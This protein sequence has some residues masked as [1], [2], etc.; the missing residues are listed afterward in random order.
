MGGQ[1]G[2]GESK[3]YYGTLAAWICEGPVESLI[4]VVADDSIVWP[5]AA[6]WTARSWPSGSIVLYHDGQL[7]QAGSTT[8]AEPPASPWVLYGLT[9]ASANGAGYTGINLLTI[10]GCRFYW[11]L[12]SQ[13]ADTILTSSRAGTDVHPPYKGICYCVLDDVKL[14]TNRAGAPNLRFLVTRKP[15]Q[16]IVTGTPSTLV[17]RQANPMAV[18]AEIFTST[19]C[20]LGLSTGRMDGTSWNATATALQSQADLMLISPIWTTK[21]TARSAIQDFTAYGD[22][23]VRYNPNNDK[24]EAGYWQHGSTPGTATVLDVNDWTAVPETEV[25]LWATAKTQAVVSFS[26]RKS[27]YKNITEQVTDPRGQRITGDVRPENLS[28]PFIKRQTQA[29]AHGY[30]W[31]RARARTPAKIILQVRRSIGLGIRPGDWVTPNLQPEPNGTTTDVYAKV[32]TRSI[33]ALVPG[34]IDTGAIT[35]TCEVDESLAPLLY[36]APPAVPIYAQ[37]DEPAELT[38]YRIIECPVQLETATQIGSLVIIAQRPTATYLGYDVWADTLGSDNSDLVPIGTQKFFGI[39]ATLAVDLSATALSSATEL[40]IDG[41]PSASVLRINVADQADTT[42]F[43][44]TPPGIVAAN[45]DQLILV[46]V[47]TSAGAIAS[48]TAGLPKVE[49]LSLVNWT[50]ISSSGGNSQ[51]A[52][53]ALRSR[54]GSTAR[55]FTTGTT[56]AWIIYRS[57]LTVFFHKDF[58]A[59]KT[60]ASIGNTPTSATIRLV[61]FTHQLSRTVTDCSDIVFNFASNSFSVPSLTWIA[62]GNTSWPYTFSTSAGGTLRLTGTW[63]DGD[64]DIV[65]LSLALTDPSGSKSSIYST[66][67]PYQSSATF[68]KTISCTTSGNCTVEATCVDALGHARTV[69]VQVTVPSAGGQVATPAVSPGSRLVRAFGPSFTVTATCATSGATIYYDIESLGVPLSGTWTTYTGAIEIDFPSTVY[70]YATKAGL[71]DS[72]I[73]SANYYSANSGGQYQSP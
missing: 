6:S 52:L 33:P 26:D 23:W 17:D 25:T 27:L 69:S 36:Q 53:D 4:A 18:L 54:L 21:G 28:R 14:G 56:E 45:D 1:A 35:L 63:S 60:N 40:T 30:E 3:D 41:T 70:F 24:V 20:G 5:Q 12:D 34:D 42:L 57:Q 16:S 38:N 11:G 64:G 49:W 39:K 62:P 65:S 72:S 32:L 48:D 47:T 66:S 68:D 10:G 15:R 46:L 19:R 13:T 29:R 71:T 7:Y 37:K 31:L 67:V 73:I 59:L 61:P 44:A 58:P 55:T 8:S 2:A 51:Y 43:S 9:N 50:L 22:F